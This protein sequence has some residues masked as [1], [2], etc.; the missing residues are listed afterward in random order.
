M[1]P[2][3]V[4]FQ[5][6]QRQTFCREFPTIGRQKYGHAEMAQFLIN[7]AQ[8]PKKD[9]LILFS[10]CSC[11]N[12]LM[13]CQKMGS[14]WLGEGTL[15]RENTFWRTTKKLTLESP[16]Q[17]SQQAQSRITFSRC[18]LQYSSLAQFVLL[19]APVQRTKQVS[20]NRAV[21]WETK[22]PNSVLAKV[23][24][25]RICQHTK[26]QQKIN[27]HELSCT[28]PLHCKLWHVLNPNWQEKS[29]ALFQHSNYFYKS[30]N[31]KNPNN[32]LWTTCWSKP[33]FE[34]FPKATGDG[35]NSLLANSSWRYNQDS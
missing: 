16:Y 17:T 26:N 3:D 19:P 32:C 7:I 18:Q 14:G 33:L 30:Y 24:S 11:G 9:L 21:L 22:N 31:S 27:Q 28:S 12:S 6:H 23:I 15:L 1:T 25:K 5:R 8:Y 2:M 13:P 4:H 34:V 10:E 20:R 29:E 35:E